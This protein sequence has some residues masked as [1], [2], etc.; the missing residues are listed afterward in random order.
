[1][2]GFLNKRPK[3]LKNYNGVLAPLLLQAAVRPYRIPFP[4]WSKERAEGTN[5]ACSQCSQ[6]RKL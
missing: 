4:S 6:R 5:I 3:P 2:A 1:M